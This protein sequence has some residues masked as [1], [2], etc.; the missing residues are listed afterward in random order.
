MEFLNPWAFL[1]LFGILIVFI[2]T[3]KL[4]FK[5]EILEKI[6]TKV[7]FSKK[8]RF[9][10]YML[11]YILIVIALARPIINHGYTTITLPKNNIAIILDASAPMKCKDI[12]PTRFDGAINKL[13]KLFKKLQLQN[14]SI[15]IVDNSP[16]LLNPPSNDYDSIIYLLKHINK[17]Y[18]FT[19]PISNIDEAID[20]AKKNIKNPIFLSISYKPPKEGIF[21]NIAQKPCLNTKVTDEGIKFT[22]SD[23]DINSIATKLN[24]MEKNKKIKILD[25]T[26]LFYYFLI[27]ALILIFIA[28]FSLPKR[29]LK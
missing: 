1:L 22:Y 6:T 27:I 26:E 2:K 13:N 12:Y 4:P 3:K 17:T 16:Y 23:K 20:A 5:K 19:S 24:E 9:I 28:S 7:P 29:T 18:L 11:A 10:L 15:I 14:V 8:K 25:K 21:Y